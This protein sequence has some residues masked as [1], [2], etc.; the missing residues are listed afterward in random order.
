MFSI[1]IVK[2]SVIHSPLGRHPV[3]VCSCHCTLNMDFSI[4]TTLSCR[5]DSDNFG[6]PD[7]LEVCL[8][9]YGIP[10]S[11]GVLLLPMSHVALIPLFID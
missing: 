11:F 10:F 9:W 7:R 6:F 3:V 4:V 1:Q 2:R 8:I 5:C